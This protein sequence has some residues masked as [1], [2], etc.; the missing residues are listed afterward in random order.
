MKIGFSFGRCIRDIVTGVVDIED[1]LV[2]VAA[3]RIESREQLAPVVAEYMYRNGY[4]MGLDENACLDTAQSLW[5]QGK[6][7][8]PRNFNAQPYHASE[9]DIWADVLP[10]TVSDNESVQ[11]AWNAYRVLLNLA[12]TVSSSDHLSQHSSF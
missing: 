6:L 2:I 3:T 5:D 10:T 11:E 4:L 12:E 8:Q 9:K 7:H 1:V